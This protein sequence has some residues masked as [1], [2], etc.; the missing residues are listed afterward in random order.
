MQSITNH[1]LLLSVYSY[2]YA[3][4][5]DSYLGIRDGEKKTFFVNNEFFQFCC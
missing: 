2:D 3:S 5:G 4:V 1:W